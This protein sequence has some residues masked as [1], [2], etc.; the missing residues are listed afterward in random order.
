MLIEEARVN[1]I[2]A[3]ST[4]VNP[5]AV[6]MRKKALRSRAP[7]TGRAGRI[8]SATIVV[9]IAIATA[10]PKDPNTEWTRFESGEIST[11]LSHSLRPL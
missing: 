6:F 10:S 11:T 1:S 3:S 5:S 7:L 2:P 4:A 8:W 9:M